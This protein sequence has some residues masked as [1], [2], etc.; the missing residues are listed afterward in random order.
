MHIQIDLHPGINPEHP[1]LLPL[2]V[3]ATAS[4]NIDPE[5][6]EEGQPLYALRLVLSG[7]FEHWLYVEARCL[8]SSCIVAL[9]AVARIWEAARLGNTEM[10]WRSCKLGFHYYAP[11][12]RIDGKRWC[13]GCGKTVD[14][15]EP[16]GAEEHRDFISVTVAHKGYCRF[17]VGDAPGE[18][19]KRPIAS[20]GAPLLYGF[21]AKP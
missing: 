6:D 7:D 13:Y 2:I 20:D 3:A 19:R 1:K 8:A 18:I 21:G 12:R 9:A 14:P 4:V 5:V 17:S 15:D 10:L 16:P 11:A